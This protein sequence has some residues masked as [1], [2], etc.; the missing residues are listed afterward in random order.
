MSKTTA[1]ATDNPAKWE[2]GTAVLVADRDR[3]WIGEITAIKPDG[4]RLLIEYKSPLGLDC[5][6][7]EVPE[8]KTPVEP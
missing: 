3:V 8:K 4:D 7:L 6:R 2:P 5:R 1:K